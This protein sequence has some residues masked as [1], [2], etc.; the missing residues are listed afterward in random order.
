MWRPFNLVAILTALLAVDVGQALSQAQGGPTA[1]GGGP[2]PT[3]VPLDSE[4]SFAGLQF[5]C[6]GVGQSKDDPKW[7]A[8]PVRFEFSNPAGDLLANGAVTIA[9]GGASLATIS[10]EGPWILMRPTD[11]ARGEY[12]VT[13]WLPGQGYRPLTQAFTVPSGGQRVI[14]L[15]FAQP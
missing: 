5:A 3:A 4:A 11:A 15:R 13:G 6:T 14:D 1:A 2:A 8:Y 12:R 10:C 7:K 9:K